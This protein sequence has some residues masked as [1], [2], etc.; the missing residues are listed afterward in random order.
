VVLN[1][2]H[3][4]FSSPDFLSWRRAGVKAVLDGRAAW[5]REAVE[6]AGLLYV[7]VGIATNLANQP[8][9]PA[10]HSK[11]EPTGRAHAGGG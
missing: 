11:R 9:A 3:P 5:R 6:A 2:L 10:V 4:E 8:N 7:G 1:T